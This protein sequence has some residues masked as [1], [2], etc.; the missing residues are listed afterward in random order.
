MKKTLPV[1]VLSALLLAACGSSDQ[2]SGGA[3]T[4]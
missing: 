4:A 2:A 3:D 1:F